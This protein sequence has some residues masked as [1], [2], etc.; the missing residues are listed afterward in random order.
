MNREE[1][2]SKLHDIYVEVLELDELTL[3]EATTASDIDA[4][5][6]LSHIELIDAIEREFGVK[7]KSKEVMDWNNVGDIITSIAQKK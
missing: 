5:D 6:S 3:T 1:I 7:F 4:W 2:L